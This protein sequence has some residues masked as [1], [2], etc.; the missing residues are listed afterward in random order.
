M[1]TDQPVDTAT[2]PTITLQWQIGTKCYG[3]AP[4]NAAWQAGPSDVDIMVEPTGPGGNSAQ[5]VR[6]NYTS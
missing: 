2:K 6:L 3:V 1:V 5:K 4:K